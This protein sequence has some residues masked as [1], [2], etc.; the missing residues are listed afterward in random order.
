MEQPTV[1]VEVGDSR[2]ATLPTAIL[3]NLS[4]RSPLLC[5]YADIRPE[6]PDVNSIVVA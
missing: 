6:S 4:V 2:A 3:I 1:D 5:R